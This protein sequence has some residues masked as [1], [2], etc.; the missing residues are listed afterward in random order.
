AHIFIDC[1]PAISAIRSP[2]TQPAQYLLRIFHDT[3]SRLHRLRK[4][5]AI[6]IHW[7]PGHEDIAGS[8]AA[9]DE[10]K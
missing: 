9:D 8:D 3:L 2:S 7:V 4:S 5:L 6:H 10:V 1:Q